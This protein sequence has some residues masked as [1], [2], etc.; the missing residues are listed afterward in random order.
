MSV[1]PGDLPPMDPLHLC[2]W[3]YVNRPDSGF[4]GLWT[5]RQMRTARDTKK[6]RQLNRLAIVIVL[7]VSMLSVAA[8]SVATPK[9]F[10]K[11]AP[12]NAPAIVTAGAAQNSYADV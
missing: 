11:D 7:A 10:L 5:R 2:Y 8:C 12:S 3:V 9:T 1:P 4:G 6:R